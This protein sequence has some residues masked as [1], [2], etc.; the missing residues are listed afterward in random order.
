VDPQTFDALA[1]ALG[2]ARSRRGLLAI[3][4]IALAPVPTAGKKK[5]RKFFGAPCASDGGCRSG[6]CQPTGD[7]GARCGKKGKPTGACACGCAEDG[8][9]GC[10]AGQDSCGGA[11]LPACPASSGG[12]TVARHPETCDCCVRPG[13]YPCPNAVELCC[14]GQDDLPCCA[15]PCDPAAANPDCPEGVAWDGNPS[16]IVC[17]YDVE[18]AVGRYCPQ[19]IDPRACAPIP[20]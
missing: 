11:C 8:E 4:A 16:I 6:H 15:R 17:R 3:S 13:G 18:C 1:R 9:C 20:G 7:P 19:G 2:G 10:P 5:K 14:T 12:R